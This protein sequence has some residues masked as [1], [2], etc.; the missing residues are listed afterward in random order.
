[1]L[2]NLAAW[3]FFLLALAI[4]PQFVLTAIGLGLVVGR[5]LKRAQP[6]PA[7]TVQEQTTP[8]GV[9]ILNEDWIGEEVLDIDDDLVPPTIR[10]HGA[11]FRNPA[12][13][14]IEAGPGEYV[15]YGA[16]GEL[17]DLCCLK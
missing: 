4:D 12:R 7:P 2:I 6:S 1:M 16:D 9:P 3:F 5:L 8:N 17:L 15:L 13:Y 11:R 14:V 10:A